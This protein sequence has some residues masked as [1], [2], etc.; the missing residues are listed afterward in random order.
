MA[1]KNVIRFLRSTK[2]SFSSFDK[3]AS[4]AWYA[5]LYGGSLGC[6][7]WSVLCSRCAFL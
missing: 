5:H 3:R 6:A 2:V 4:G 1:A 7:A